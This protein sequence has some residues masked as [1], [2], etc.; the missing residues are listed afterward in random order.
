MAIRFTPHIQRLPD[1][2]PFIGP[3]TLERQSSRPFKARLGANESAF[4]IS[5]NAQSAIVE[6]AATT[7]CSWYGD[8]ENY[9][10]RALLAERHGVAMDNI[11]VDA[12]IDSLLGLSI[13][14]FVSPG[15]AV[16][17]SLGAYPTVNYHVNG[18]GGTLYTVPYRDKHEDPV[19]LIEAAHAHGAQLLYLANPDNPMGSCLEP[20][21]ITT[22]LN[23]LPQS[24]LLMLDEAYVEFMDST[25][26]LPLDINDDRLIRFRTFSK[27]YGLAGMRVGYAIAHADIIAGFNR[28][29]NHF[30][31][32][33]L[34]Q[35]AAL[36]S[37]EDTAFLSR[38]VE[39]VRQGRERIYAMSTELNLTYVSSSTNFVTV[40]TGSVQRADLLLKQLAS[41]GVFMRK[42][43]MTPQ[44]SHIRIGVG[45][46]EDQRFLESVLVPLLQSY[47]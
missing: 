40:E 12:G 25:S 35:I 4:G 47:A 21:D 44:S 45:T 34:A 19:A 9:E 46:E 14:L 16:V 24:C 7:G 26:A 32:S 3:E 17:T 8:P 41:A 22:L 11:C 18:Y 2:I 27:A 1:T 33:R 23:N 20:A 38:V 31:V 36:A 10:L 28:I 42:P 37:L 15:Q 43:G 13:R 6:A 30:G 5:P 39:K 29:R